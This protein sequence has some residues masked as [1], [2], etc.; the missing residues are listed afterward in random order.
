MLVRIAPIAPSVVHPAP[1]VDA[2]AAPAASEG[3]LDAE[4]ARLRAA[5]V[6]VRFPEIDETLA[7]AEPIAPRL[8]AIHA[9]MERATADMVVRYTGDG[10]TVSPVQAWQLEDGGHFN[11]LP[12]EPLPPTRRVG[13][14]PEA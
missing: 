13:T 6:R 10:T 8:E 12:A 5:S 1:R 4:L 9:A 2:P 14:S 3:A 7:A 11:V